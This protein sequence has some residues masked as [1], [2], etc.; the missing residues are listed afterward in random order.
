MGTCELAI[1]VVSWGALISSLMA[2]NFKASVPW[3]Y[4]PNDG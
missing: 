2:W 1:N 4:A 3:V